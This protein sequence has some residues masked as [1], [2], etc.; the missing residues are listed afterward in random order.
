MTYTCCFDVGLRNLAVC[1]MSSTDKQDMK[2]YKIH[3]WDVYNVLDA[4]DYKCT[5]VFKNGKICN[6][7]CTMKY[8]E[9]NIVIHC[10][11]THFPKSIKSNK[12]NVFKKKSIDSYLL[13]D[14]AKLFINK[15]QFL[16]DNND[17]FKILDDIQIELQ[18]KCNPKMLFISHVLYG[19]LVQLFMNRNTK[20]RFVRAAIKLKAYTGPPIECKLKSAYTKRKW[21]SIQ[22]GKWILENQFDNEQ[23]NKWIYIYELDNK[24]DD[25]FDT[26]N[27]CINAIHGVP[28]TK[29][30]NG[31]CIK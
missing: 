26:F 23:I 31:K 7:K 1:I 2:T 16:Y 10:C 12:K 28:N 29:S 5:G 21:L 4:D 19:K 14:I 30:K 25:L 6:R 3:L 15:I 24:Q 9:N 13:Q 27:M 22:Y 20:I 8:T 11:K 18:P 17:I